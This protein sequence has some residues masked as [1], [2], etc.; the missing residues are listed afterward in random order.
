VQ[1]DP[2]LCD[3]SRERGLFSD[4]AHGEYAPGDLRRK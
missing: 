4:C 3:C 1:P 2:P